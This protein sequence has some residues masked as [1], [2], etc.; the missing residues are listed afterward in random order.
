MISLFLTLLSAQS[1][2]SPAPQDSVV[3]QRQDADRHLLIC[4]TR[5]SEFKGFPQE[6][7]AVWDVCLKEANTR[8]LS[9]AIPLIQGERALVVLKES[10]PGLAESDPIAYARA[11]LTIEA[12]SSDLQLP[13]P[14]LSQAWLL[15]VSNPSSRQN[16]EAVRTVTVRVDE[17]KVDDAALVEE[18]LRRHIGDMG[19][20][21]S[22]P[23]Q[24][25]AANASIY[26]TV[27]GNQSASIRRTSRMNFHEVTLNMT[28]GPIE[29]TALNRERSPL[30]AQGFST[31][32]S[33]DQAFRDAADA[34]AKALAQAFLRQVVGELF[35]PEQAPL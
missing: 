25:D 16:L 19:F 29:Y 3:E 32:T 6:E 20:K 14:D 2:P 31:P 7:L 27:S 1:T 13:L 22:L 24:A 12:S 4:R 30:S 5:A 10:K 8:K 33:P 9:L 11:V 23:D 15:L 17:L 28:T 35:S 18:L 34:A 21:V 26:F